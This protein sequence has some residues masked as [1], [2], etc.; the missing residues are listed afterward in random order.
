MLFYFSS[1]SLEVGCIGRY[2]VV[3]HRLLKAAPDRAIDR[4]L[5]ALIVYLMI[6]GLV[7]QAPRIF[8]IHT[9]VKSGLVNIYDGLPSCN[10]VAEFYGKRLPGDDI[11]LC[12]PRLVHH[13]AGAWPNTMKFIKPR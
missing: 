7:P 3:V 5:I 2:S 8:L 6:I 1:E 11:F 4:N 9:A 13:L 12:Q 10:Y